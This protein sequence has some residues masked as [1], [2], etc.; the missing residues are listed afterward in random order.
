MLAEIACRGAM[1]SPLDARLE[2][3]SHRWTPAVLLVGNGDGKQLLESEWICWERHL[4]RRKVG[5]VDLPAQRHPAD[6][7]AEGDDRE[8][9]NLTLVAQ[10]LIHRSPFLE[11]H[12][13]DAAV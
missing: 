7:Q 4:P 2:R 5:H 1:H 13:A 8:I 3:C 10:V 12:H 9:D 11:P 6:P